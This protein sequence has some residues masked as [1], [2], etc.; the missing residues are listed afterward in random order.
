[1]S[2]ENTFSCPNCGEE[3]AKK[4]LACPSCGSDANT[5]WNE[6]SK[7]YDGVDL[8]DEDFDYEERMS[9]IKVELQHLN[10]ESAILSEQIQ[11]NLT[12]LGI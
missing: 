1:M 11:T 12:E 8:P 6:T 4:T 3:V 10:K 2:Q 7:V 9:E 5:G